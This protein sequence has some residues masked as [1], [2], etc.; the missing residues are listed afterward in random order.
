MTIIAL[1]NVLGTHI[2]LQIS[3]GG[4]WNANINGTK[5]EKLSLLKRRLKAY[6]CRLGSP[7]FKYFI[8]LH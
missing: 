1:I 7:N 2:F 5:I 3:L 8:F 6:K 4:V